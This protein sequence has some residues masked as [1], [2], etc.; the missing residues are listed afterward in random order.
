M[1]SLEVSSLTE[2]NTLNCSANELKSINLANNVKLTTLDCSDN[3]LAGL[4]LSKNVA[5]ENLNCSV[6]DIAT[7]DLT[8]NAVLS[9]IFC[10]DCH[11][12]SSVSFPE[13]LEAIQQEA[14]MNCT[15]LTSLTFPASITSLGQDAFR[16]CTKLSELNIN[17]D[18]IGSSFYQN[19]FTGAPVSTVNMNE[20][21][22]VI[23]ESAFV[24]A[25]LN[26]VIIPAS[27]TKIEKR[28]FYRQPLVAVSFAKNSELQGIGSYAFYECENLESFDASNCHNIKTILAGSYLYGA[29]YGCTITDFKIGTV[30]PP[31][32]DENYSYLN[33][34]NLH[35]P[36]G[37]IDAYKAS[38]WGSFCANI[39]EL[40]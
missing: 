18:I 31:D 22:T 37:C 35:V 34:T 1:T 29:F 38:A 8:S 15:S 5:L 16:N 20:N 12:L 7:L 6:T 4:E 36:K 40:E 13:T 30:T 39:L 11:S 19:Y 33:I 25:K 23:G 32:I 21:V 17:S 10:K 3:P 14:F 28:A 2:L 9:D 24:G 27:V 26:S